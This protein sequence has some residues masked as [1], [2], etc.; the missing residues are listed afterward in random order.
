MRIYFFFCTRYKSSKGLL[1]DG[2]AL[3]LSNSW[4]IV[5]RPSKGVIMSPGKKNWKS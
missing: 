5:V 3:F 1:S 4:V 2:G